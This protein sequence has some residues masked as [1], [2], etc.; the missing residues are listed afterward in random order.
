VTTTVTTTTRVTSI[1]IRSNTDASNAVSRLKWDATPRH[2][3]IVISATSPT[4][5]VTRMRVIAQVATLPARRKPTTHASVARVMP[6]ESP[7][8][9]GLRQDTG[10]SHG[11]PSTR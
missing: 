7:K 2:R 3:C 8:T 10:P 4:E 6:K 1:P 5:A 11:P 9:T